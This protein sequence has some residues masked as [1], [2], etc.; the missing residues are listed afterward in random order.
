M[1]RNIE[2]NADGVTLRG[3]LYVPDGT[4]GP[5][6]AVVM[7]HG[8]TAVK[9]MTLDRYAEVFCKGGLAVVVYDNRC[10]GES[11]G[12]PRHDIDPTAQRRDYRCAITFAQQQ[13]EIDPNRVG[14]WGTS[15][16]GGAVLAVAALDRRVRAVVS[17]VPFVNGWKNIQQFLRLSDVAGFMKMLDEDRARRMKG[18]P[19]QYVQV[20]AD[21][22]DEP[23]AFPGLRTYH[24]FHK[25]VKEVPN[26]TW[27]NKVT[28]RSLEYLL[29]YDVTG[30]MPL[31]A[32]TPLLMIVSHADSATPTDLALE[33][34]Q[35][36]RDPKELHVIK[37]D[38][39]AS[40]LEGFE[41]TSA[42]ARDF[43]VKHL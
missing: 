25:Y 17:Q 3:W 31:I 36:A 30:Y 37:A 12:Q 7:S 43:F 33:M 16:T 14:V 32:P 15:Y 1:R 5:Y 28:L 29:E 10:L 42:A 13:K 6:P 20:A 9:E 4:K 2:F 34:F 26:C 22:D 19:S 35:L 11:D 23:C 8:F 38:H 40:Y 27:Q 21:K 24:Y 41:G 18:E 39:Y